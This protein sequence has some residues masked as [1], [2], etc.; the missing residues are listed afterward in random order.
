MKSY[1]ESMASPRLRDQPA[2][3]EADKSAP[4]SLRWGYLIQLALVQF[5][6]ALADIRNWAKSN[7]L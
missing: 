2:M 7:G 6:L 3:Q 5:D 1:R 4:F